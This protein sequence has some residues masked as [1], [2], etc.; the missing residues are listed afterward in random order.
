MPAAIWSDGEEG[1]NE[2]VYDRGQRLLATRDALDRLMR[3]TAQHLLF[4]IRLRVER[5][6]TRHTRYMEKEA[7]D[8]VRITRYLVLRPGQAAEAAPGSARARRGPRRRARA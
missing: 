8:E 4:E 5:V 2:M 6:E 7:F 1:D 3:R